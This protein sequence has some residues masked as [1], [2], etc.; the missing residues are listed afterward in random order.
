MEGL[1]RQHQTAPTTGRLSSDSMSEEYNTYTTKDLEGSN[2][3]IW[4]VDMV[5]ELSA[6]K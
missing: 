6:A 1:E 3:G 4:V 5:E 2:Q